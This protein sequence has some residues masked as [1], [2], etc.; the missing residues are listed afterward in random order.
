MSG[1]GVKG[2]HVFSEFIQ[3]PDKFA[4]KQKLWRYC[5]IGIRERRTFR[6]QGRSF[7]LKHVFGSLRLERGC[8]KTWTSKKKIPR[9]N[10][11][12]CS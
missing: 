3:S 4:T 2:A 8:P 11:P 9:R 5:K 6:H 10:M 7:S 12:L 1:I